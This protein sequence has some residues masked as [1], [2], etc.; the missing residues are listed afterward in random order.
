M[1]TPRQQLSISVSVEEYEAWVEL[2]YRLGYPS[3]TA[4]IRDAM[5]KLG[6]QK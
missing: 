1:P 6:G 3:L 4:A 2:Q 5:E